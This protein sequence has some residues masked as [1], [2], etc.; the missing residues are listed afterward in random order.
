MPC[1]SSASFGWENILKD[2]QSLDHSSASLTRFP[3]LS[4]HVC[5]GIPTATVPVG[6][7]KDACGSGHG[8]ASK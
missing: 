1:L 3:P 2:L 6:A 8:V 5:S 7:L 4:F